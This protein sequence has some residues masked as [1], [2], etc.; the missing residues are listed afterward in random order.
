[1][2]KRSACTSTLAIAFSRERRVK[3]LIEHAQIV[4]LN[5]ENEMVAGMKNDTGL[6]HLF[7]H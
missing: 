4:V 7:N 2:V 3:C 6:P 5:Y 1:M